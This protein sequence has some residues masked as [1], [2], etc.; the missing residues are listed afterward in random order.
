M[1]RT[2]I[3]LLLLFLASPRLILADDIPPPPPVAQEEA[4]VPAVESSA[5][6]YDRDSTTPPPAEKAP[7]PDSVPAAAES[8]APEAPS[9]T[10]A[11][12]AIPLAPSVAPAPIRIP[13]LSGEWCGS[14]KSCSN[15]H[16]G[17]MRA[18]FC[19]LCNGDY[20]VT[21]CGRF[22][23]VIPFR[24][25]TTLKTTGYSDGVVY[26]SGSQSLGPIL[27]TFSYNAWANERQ[28][29]SGYSASKD[30][31]EFHLAR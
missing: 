19:R 30:R 6:D 16:N 10:D 28:F 25:T 20:Q 1:R 9:L 3:P 15:G 14:W 26:L 5:S 21:F 18:S 31:G 22:C 12:P 4:P 23:K 29:A 27:G 7:A 8:V 24:Y 17:P 11:G 2:A 13:D